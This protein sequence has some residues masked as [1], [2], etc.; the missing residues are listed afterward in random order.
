MKKN[1]LLILI[2]IYSVKLSSQN[3]ELNLE[4]NYPIPIDNNFFGENYNGII[5]IGVGYKFFEINKFDFGISLNGGIFQT[6]TDQSGGFKNFKITTYF[7]QPKIYG[8]LNFESIEKL[9]L[10]F[11]IGYTTMIFDVAGTFNGLVLPEQNNRNGFNLNFG[12]NYDITEKLF[13]QIQYDFIKL[14]AQ[15]EAS[16]RNYDRNIN[17]LKIGFGYK[18]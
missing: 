15:N 8:E 2:I 6:E 7:V 9:H 4:L 16:N 13:C 10:K 1:L 18:I 5:D 14:G 11:G 12:L 17:I 3:S